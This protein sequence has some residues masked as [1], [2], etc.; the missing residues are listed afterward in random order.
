RM[1]R[2]TAA[3]SGERG[4]LPPRLPGGA[5]SGVYTRRNPI[6]SV[7]IEVSRTQ[8][9]LSRARRRIS[10]PA[11]VAPPAIPPVTQG[12]AVGSGRRPPATTG[13]IPPRAV[14]VA[15]LPLTVRAVCPHDCPDACGMTVTVA[16]GRAVKLRGDA[17]HPFTN[18]FLC[19]KVSRYLER[20]YH[21]DRLRYPMKRVGPKGSGRFERIS[22][23]EAIATT[24]EH[25][26]AIAS[27]P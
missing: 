10:R 22:W 11:P 25:F 15:S 20:V 19:Q 8:H 7:I 23:D 5:D 14:A 18:G 26:A 13:K 1:S 21:P 9:R 3:P 6:S 24:A 2:P 16:D 17:D 4:I 27:S 12:V